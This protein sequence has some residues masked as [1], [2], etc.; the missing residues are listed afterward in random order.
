VSL[1][2]NHNHHKTTSTT[3]ET[4]FFHISENSLQVHCLHFF[5]IEKFSL[6]TVFDEKRQSIPG[7]KAVNGFFHRFVTNCC[8]KIGLAV[9]VNLLSVSMNPI[10]TRSKL[11]RSPPV[12]RKLAAREVAEP[13][14]PPTRS[15]GSS[16]SDRTLEM[17]PEPPQ[18]ESPLSS[19]F[20][21]PSKTLNSCQNE[22][23]IM[24]ALSELKNMMRGLDEKFSNKIDNLSQTVSSIKDEIASVKHEVK[25]VIAAQITEH[26]DQ[27]AVHDAR[28]VAVETSIRE[29]QNTTEAATKA[30]DLIIR[31]VP[32]L[33]NEDPRFGPIN[34]YMSI[35]A[36]IGYNSNN[37]PGAVIT[38][39]GR[40][41]PDGNSDPPLLVRFG[42]LIDREE[43]YRLYFRHKTLN[44]S[45]LGFSS[46]Q[47]VYISE[48]LTK[49]D[50]EIHG[51]AMKMRHERK[52]HS[53]STSKGVVFVRRNQDDRPTPIR[54]MSELTD[55]ADT[56]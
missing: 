30:A 43:F 49:R 13:P 36:A 37:T 53:V 42:R 41:R 47:R 52:L 20:A 9:A 10:Q 34:F 14:V 23:N 7:N 54:A 27:L 4:K 2:I 45:E 48:N 5:C 26:S 11:V 32:M 24:E 35:A 15:H 33:S 12:T 39:L 44:L 18:L 6:P 8:I 1:H 28:I 21:A 55:V 56:T 17:S 31:G 38:R 29:L 46:N 16:S 51:A 19:S 25:E 50:Q 22:S 40:K 3:S